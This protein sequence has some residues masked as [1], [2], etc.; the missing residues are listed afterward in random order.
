MPN[1]TFADTLSAGIKADTRLLRDDDLA[2]SPFSAESDF[3]GVNFKLL[4]LGLDE[5]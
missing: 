1:R 5:K 4:V 2:E 3:G